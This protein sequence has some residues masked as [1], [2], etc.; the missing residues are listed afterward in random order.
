MRRPAPR[1]VRR[2]RS[3]NERGIALIMAIVAIAILTA[4]AA[5]FAY[6]SRVDLQLAANQRDELRAHYLAKSGL[7]MSRMLLKFQRQLDSSPPPGLAQAMQALGGATGGPP[8]S[9]NI[10]LW[11]MAKV[12]CYM[13]QGLLSSG[14][15]ADAESAPSGKFTHEEV[16]AAGG[17]NAPMVKRSFGGFEGCFSATIS[18]EEEKFNLNSL[19]QLQAA[20]QIAAARGMAL[21]GDKRFEFLYDREDANG[22]KTTPQDLL[23]SIRDWI[24][25]DEVQSSLNLTGQG[26]AFLRGFSDENAGYDRHTP[27][28]KAKNAKFDSLEELNMVHGVNDRIMAAF[29][30]RLTVYPDINRALNINTDDPVMLWLAVLAITDKNK[31]DP[32]LLS[33]VFQDEVIKRIRTARMFSFMAMSVQDFLAVV[34]SMGIPVDARIQANIQGN[35]AVSDKSQTFSIKSVGEA[36]QVQKTIHAV[37]RL[38]DQLGKLV[39]WREE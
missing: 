32:R 9:L 6:N 28:Y 38:D 21:F 31:P 1:G 34:A 14:P 23:I 35:R 18:D 10:Q 33:P 16:P 26:D 24:D 29:R 2:R 30:D 4:V 37:V 36:G 12:D 22:V 39:H 20:S 11:R 15:G 17:E 7:A 8:P 19:D 25:E 27:R 5:D 3:A 13:L